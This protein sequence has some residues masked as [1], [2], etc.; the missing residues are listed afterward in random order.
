MTKPPENT[1][2]MAPFCPHCNEEIPT[3]RRYTRHEQDIRA[4]ADELGN[5][6]TAEAEVPEADVYECPH[7]NEEI[8]TIN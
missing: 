8:E 5:L 1:D 3:V 2:N 7:C 6:F 4:Y